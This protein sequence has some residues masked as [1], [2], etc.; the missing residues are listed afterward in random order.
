MKTKITVI[1]I[2][3]IEDH[4]DDFGNLVTNR[5]IITMDDPK[6]HKIYYAKM[7]PQVHAG[8]FLGGTFPIYS[9]SITSHELKIIMIY[10][11]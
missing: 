10:E 8:V 3:E 9:P 5:R 2:T 6:S 7:E 4:W 1:G 11:N